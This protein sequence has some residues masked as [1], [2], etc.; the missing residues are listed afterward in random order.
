M[1]PQDHLDW[2]ADL[3]CAG[4]YDLMAQSYAFPMPVYVDDRRQVVC[5]AAQMW[6][7][8]QTLHALLRASGHTGVRPRMVSVELPRRG[9]FRLWTDWIG[10]R[11]GAETVPLFR[12]LCYNAGT[13]A[14]FRTEMLRFE[15]LALPQLTEIVLAA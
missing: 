1:S 6:P 9:R 2:M 15:G 14:S 3:L 7:M 11:E 13:H 5:D 8:F 10:L 4:R 12:T